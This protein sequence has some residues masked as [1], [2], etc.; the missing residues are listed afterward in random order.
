MKNK[1]IVTQIMEEAVD[2]SQRVFGDA[3]RQVWLYGSCARGDSDEDSDIDF[4]VVLSEPIETW[5]MLDTVYC[6]FSINILNRY[7]ELPS[8]LITDINKFNSG[9]GQLYKNVK[10]EGVL[11]YGK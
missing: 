1:P 11:Y 3:L 10:E 9:Q 8:V 6:D 7:G 2:V 4:M 5:K